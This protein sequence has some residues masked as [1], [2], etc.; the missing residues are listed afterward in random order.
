MR[1]PILRPGRAAS[2]LVALLASTGLKAG[3][4]DAAVPSPGAI[5]LLVNKPLGPDQI[6]LCRAALM[7][8]RA[9]SRATA[10]RVARVQGA[11]GLVPA[12]REALAGES[13]AGAAREQILALGWLVGA[14][15]QDALF[16]AARRFA[17][18]LDDALV[19]GL[20]LR[21]P[22]ALAL[23]GRLVEQRVEPRSWDAFFLWATRGGND[24]LAEAGSAAAA[25]GSPQAWGALFAASA[26][27][28]QP[29]AD[30]TVATA[31]RATPPSIRTEAYLHVLR[32]ADRGGAV[33]AETRGALAQAPETDPAR[34]S[35]PSAALAFELLQRAL[36]HA[37]VDRTPLLRALDREALFRLG[38][39]HAA[40]RRLQ[41][42]EREALG[43]VR[44]S[45]KKWVENELEHGRDPVEAR[46]QLRGNRIRTASDVPPG[47]IDDLVAVTGCPLPKQPAWAGGEARFDAQGTLERVGF[48]PT[49]GEAACEPAARALLLMSMLPIDRP[50]LGG[51]VDMLVLPLSQDFAACVGRAEPVPRHRA[52]SDAEAPAAVREPRK[53]RNVPPSYPAAAQR[54]GRQGVVIVEAVVG[55]EGCVRS[56]E[57]VSSPHVD[58]A[59]E[60]IRSVIQWRYTPTLLDGRAVPVVMTVTVNFRLR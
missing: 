28:G 26:R 39:D 1:E 7:G 21:G 52:T 47:V 34:A 17:G 33:G 25:I 8:S 58:L 3:P 29:L 48:Y 51:Q 45:D 14:P 32:L 57:V 12:L 5:A 15:A 13:D 24:A 2:L 18:E 10:A 56:A 49:Q 9:E 11:T 23:A 4:A 35:D 22:Q 59:G 30:A 54:E 6:A 60:A 41:R 53:T 43:E 37:P 55:T 44:F 16:A 19:L 27:A 20:A 50:P 40:L 46:N 36:G 42:P 31:V 38:R